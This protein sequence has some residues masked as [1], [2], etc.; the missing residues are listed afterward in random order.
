MQPSTIAQW[1]S[2]GTAALTPGSGSARL[3]AQILLALSMDTS[4]AFLFAWPDSKISAAQSDAFADLIERRAGGEPVNY[5][6]GRKEFWSVELAVTPDTLIPRPDTERLVELALEHIPQ[7]REVTIADIGTGSG[8]IA[9]ALALERPLCRVFATDV[10]DACV[11]LARHNIARLDIPNIEVHQGDLFAPLDDMLFD[12]V[13]S[14]PPYIRDDDPHLNEGDVRFEPR[15]ALTGG[16]DGL[17]VIKRLLVTTGG[18]LH[19]GGTVLIEHSHDQGGSVRALC[20]EAGL[21]N[22]NTFRDYGGRERVTIAHGS[23]THSSVTHS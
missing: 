5:I 8:A 16:A 23:V 4:R 1:L 7:K 18:Y 14:N 12:V 2:H 11:T 20:A 15:L 13:I 10:S 3:D 17:D 19:D 22:A 9:I 21:H 6:T